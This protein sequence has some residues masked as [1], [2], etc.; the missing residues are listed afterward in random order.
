LL[1]AFKVLHP[2]RVITCTAREIKETDLHRCLNLQRSDE[3]GELAMTFDQ[4]ITRLEMVFK[5]QRQFIPVEAQLG[6]EPDREASDQ[7]HY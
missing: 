2:I 7:R 6:L 5:R 3:L 1:C 4:M